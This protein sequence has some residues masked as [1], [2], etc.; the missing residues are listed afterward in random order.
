MI[1]TLFFEYPDDPTS[2]LIED[3]YMFGE[4]LL[5][6]PLF[7]A[8]RFRKL[9][10]PPG[11]WTDY[12]TRKTYTGGRWHEV[13]TVDIPIVLMVR[14]H[15]VIPHIEVAPS[16][17][18]LDWSRIELRLFSSDQGPVSGLFSLPEESTVKLNLR[19]RGGKFELEEDPSQ[20]RID[21]TITVGN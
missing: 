7:E 19:T 4:N 10:L 13:E 6:A 16:T 1:R 3:E 15:S 2:W 20:G 11:V 12:Q 9:Y 18:D 21:W 5:I 17:N 14:D 8:D